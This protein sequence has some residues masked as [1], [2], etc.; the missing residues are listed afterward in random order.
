MFE[1]MIGK[2]VEVNVTFAS[3]M[4]SDWSLMAITYA[5]KLIGT[6]GDFIVLDAQEAF[7]TVGGPPNM[8]G[9][10]E[11]KQP[12]GKVMLINTKWI[13]HIAAV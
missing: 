3:A 7:Y 9:I 12:V 4:R 11:K 10:A 6:D 8:M 2:N 5:G 1:K 13:I